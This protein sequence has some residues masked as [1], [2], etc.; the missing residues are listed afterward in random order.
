MVEEIGDII[1]RKDLIGRLLDFTYKD[2]MLLEA[3]IHEILPSQKC[4]KSLCIDN[5]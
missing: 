3:P 4:V 1:A 2:K 5:D